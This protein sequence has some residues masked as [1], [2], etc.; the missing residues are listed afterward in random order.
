V[1]QL[2]NAFWNDGK[3]DVLVALIA[4]DFVLGVFVALKARTFRLSYVADF[5]RKDV[6]FKIGGYF[7]LYA[8]SYYAGQE[9]ILSIPG[10]DLGVV[11]GA[12]YVTVVAAMVGSIL[13]S[14]SELGILPGDDKEPDPAPTA[15][16][17]TGMLTAD[18][19]I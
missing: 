14:I 9:D 2:I 3:V 7:A 5:L 13:N 16:S 12:A 6:V 4:L 10:L 15:L 18:E 1:V 17:A 8:A 19:G 11:A